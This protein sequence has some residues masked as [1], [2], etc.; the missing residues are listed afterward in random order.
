MRLAWPSLRHVFSIQWNEINLPS[1]ERTPAGPKILQGI[2]RYPP[3]LLNQNPLDLI[4]LIHQGSQYQPPTKYER[5]PWEVFLDKQ[6]PEQEETTTRDR[7]LASER[8]DVEQGRYEQGPYHNFST[9]D[10]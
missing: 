9:S 3:N 2:H 4:I 8:S 1:P 10:T 7:N 6:D 5:K